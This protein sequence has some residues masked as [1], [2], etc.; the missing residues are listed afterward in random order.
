MDMEPRER[1]REHE[2]G[3]AGSGP[4]GEPTPLEDV[5]RLGE[6]FLAR[7]DEA[8]SRALSGDSEAFL[9][10]SRQLGGQ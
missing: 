7:A 10:A 8:I 1:R 3:P 9:R 5:R 2:D 4:L 6:Q